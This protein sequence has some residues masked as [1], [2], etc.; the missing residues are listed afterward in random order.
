M[1]YVHAMEYYSAMK[2]EAT[3]AV[4]KNKDEFGGC[5]GE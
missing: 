3:S 2:K 1:W 4:H 5:Y